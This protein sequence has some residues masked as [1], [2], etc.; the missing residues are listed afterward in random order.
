LLPTIDRQIAQ[1]QPLS[2]A[3]L[4]AVLLLPKLLQR[5]DDVEALDRR[6]MSRAALR[7]LVDETVAPLA[8]R[9]ALSRAR[10]TQLTQ[11]LVAFQRLCEPGWKPRARQ[12][13]THRPYFE[14]ALALFGLMVEATGEGR[15][16][17]EP[18]Q[19]AAAGRRER[20]ETETVSEEPLTDGGTAVPVAVGAGDARRRRRR[21]RRRRGGASATA[22]DAG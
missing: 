19:R 14:D 13:F 8:A 10:S 9:L 1:G 18:W 6:P 20:A 15:A 11:A 4:L 12:Q 21:R 3:T 5:R 2:D 17:L 16:A 22:R 7:Q